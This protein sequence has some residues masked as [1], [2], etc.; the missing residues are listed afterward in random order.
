MLRQVFNFQKLFIMNIFNVFDQTSAK[1]KLNQKPYIPMYLIIVFSCMSTLL[2]GQISTIVFYFFFMIGFSAVTIIFLRDRTL[3]GILPIK[4]RFIVNNIM[5]FYLPVPIAFVVLGFMFVFILY[6]IFSIFDPSSI[7][8]LMG[9]FQP[10]KIAGLLKF[11]LFVFFADFCLNLLLLLVFLIRTKW[12]QLTVAIGLSAVVIAANVGLRISSRYIHYQHDPIYAWVKSL[13]NVQYWLLISA[14]V[15]FL[16][17]MYTV[18]V[19]M[20]KHLV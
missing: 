6:N 4:K 15:I 16:S 9:P 17:L 7:S 14:M 8:S 2:S 5:L 11:I 10:W 13:G 12:I 19:R 20:Y 3:F 1:N 18:C